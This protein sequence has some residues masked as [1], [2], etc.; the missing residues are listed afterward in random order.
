MIR[1]CTELDAHLLRAACYKLRIPCAIEDLI[2]PLAGCDCGGGGFDL[3]TAARLFQVVGL[4]VTHYTC[5]LDGLPREALSTR[6]PDSLT[7]IQVQGEH[8]GHGCRWGMLE[9]TGRGKGNLILMS[10]IGRDEVWQGRLRDVF[11]GHCLVISH[12]VETALRRN[13]SD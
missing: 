2:E 7:L 9:P 4:D 8:C 6:L 1:C 11:T 13:K 3:E 5:P 10:E 12:T